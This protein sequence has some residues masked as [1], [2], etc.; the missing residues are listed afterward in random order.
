MRAYVLLILFCFHQA[1]CDRASQVIPSQASENRTVERTESLDLAVETLIDGLVARDRE[2]TEEA[3]KKGYKNTVGMAD[4]KW[5]S[6]NDRGTRAVYVRGLS[7]LAMALG[8]IYFA[9][10]S[11]VATQRKAN[12]LELQF[13]NDSLSAVR[14]IESKLSSRIEAVVSGQSF[15]DLAD[16]ITKFY[17]N[18]PLMKDKPVLWVLAVPLYKE[19]EESK[20]K[21]KRTTGNDTIRVPMSKKEVLN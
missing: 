5:W 1:G 15:G 11:E 13:G 6:Q 2:S 20:P 3:H 14:E 21:E 17:Q 16:A 8:T 18:K 19:L 7:D 12:G 10:V 4:G 9:T